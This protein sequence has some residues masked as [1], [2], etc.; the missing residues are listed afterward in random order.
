ME[1]KRAN[2]LPEPD[3]AQGFVAPNGSKFELVKEED[4]R[5][6]AYSESQTARPFDVLYMT[7]STE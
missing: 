4:D 7:I 3:S 2:R 5:R 6:D 1:T